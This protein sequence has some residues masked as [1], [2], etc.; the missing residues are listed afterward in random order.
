MDLAAS[1][2]NY[3][4]VEELYPSSGIDHG[5]VLIHVPDEVVENPL[6]SSKN[7]SSKQADEILNKIEFLFKKNVSADDILVA[8]PY[9][10]K[11]FYIN[12]S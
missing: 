2:I 4:R 7:T 5:Y 8:C 9:E 12:N 3:I 1:G 11:V 10:S 6:I